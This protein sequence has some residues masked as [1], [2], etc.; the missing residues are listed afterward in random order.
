MDLPHVAAT[1]PGVFVLSV[2]GLDGFY[3]AMLRKASGDAA[4]AAS[5]NP[6]AVP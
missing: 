1:G 4:E 2:D 3:L 6:A 5:A